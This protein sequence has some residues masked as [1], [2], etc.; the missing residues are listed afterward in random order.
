MHN[1]K[2]KDNKKEID[3]ILASCIM[4]ISQAYFSFSL[5]PLQ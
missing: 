2:G 1:E 3:V 4:Y 5:H